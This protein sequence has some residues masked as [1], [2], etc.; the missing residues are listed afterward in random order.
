M[1]A[2]KKFENL[3]RNSVL[4]GVGACNDRL[5]EAADKLDQLFV[6]GNALVNELVQRGEAVESELKA[7]LEGKYMLNEKFINLKAKFGFNRE[8]QEQQI[9]KLSTKVDELIEQVA[10]LAE[11]K[12]AELAAKPKSTTAKKTTARKPAAKKPAKAAEKVEAPKAEAKAETPAPAKKPAAK[13][14]TARKPAAKS[15]A[16]KTAASKTTSKAPAKP[17]VRKTAAKKDDTAE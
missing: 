13:K 10:K 9:D 1:N 11:K 12:A 14:T 4:A 3:G 15:T 7:K 16:S 6:D 17:R 8:Y 2:V 5:R